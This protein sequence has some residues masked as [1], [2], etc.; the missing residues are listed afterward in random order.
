MALQRA[1]FTLIELL[2]VIAIIAVLAAILFPVFAQTKAAAK[3]SQCLSQIRQV[4]LATFLYAGDFD[5]TFPAL[6]PVQPP[7]NGGGNSFRPFD[8][9]VSPY[10]KSDAVF[11]CPSA[12]KTWIDQP[13]SLWWDGSYWDKEEKR[14]YAVVGNIFTV[15]G[16]SS[17][18]DANTGIT[19]GEKSAQ[20]I[21]R[22]TT[23]FDSPADTFA[24][25]EVFFSL[26]HFTDSWLGE[27]EGS[28]FT[29]CDAAELAGRTYPS[30]AP[31]DQLP[32]PD[33]PK[34]DYAYQPQFFHTAG[35]NYLFVDGHAKLFN[36]NQA[37]HNDFWLFKASKP[38][39]TV[40]P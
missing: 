14:S 6:A 10:V 34:Y 15:Q 24:L 1:A 18:T 27:Y 31:S 21:G 13:L 4:G 22:T 39:E 37:R 30:S 35:Q 33:L 8:T 16:G 32:C 36:F 17:A 40:S 5:D 23:Q 11:Y 9:M 28:G 12:P 25:A 29:E 26:Q 20:A 38:T 2:V 7:I 3:Q 19:I